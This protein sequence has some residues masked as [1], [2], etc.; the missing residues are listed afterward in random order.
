MG[1][2]I[3]IKKARGRLSEK[4]R[5]IENEGENQSLGAPEIDNRVGGLFETGEHL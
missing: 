1:G 4:K 5:E 2:A 3:S